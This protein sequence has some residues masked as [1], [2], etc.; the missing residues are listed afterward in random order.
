[1]FS[2]TLV[3][4]NLQQEIKLRKQGIMMVVCLVNRDELNILLTDSR[5]VIERFYN[6]V[7]VAC[8]KSIEYRIVRDYD[9]TKLYIFIPN[10]LK[11]AK[12][13]ACSIYSQV[14]LDFNREFPESY[15]KCSIQSIKFPQNIYHDVRKLLSLLNYGNFISTNKSYYFNYDD[16]PVDIETLRNKNTNLNLLRLSLFRKDAKFV[17]QP[18]VDRKTGYISYYECLLRIKDKGNK[19]VSVGPM[20]SDAE[21]KGLISIVDSTAVEMAI[22]ELN[23]DKYISLA[24]N[25]SSIGVL[26][27]KL[28]KKIEV[29]LKKYNV[30]KRLIIEITETSL[31]DDFQGTKQFIDILHKYGCRFALDDFGSGFTSFQQLLNLH[32]DIIKIDGSYIR[33]ILKNNR[34]R[35]FVKALIKLSADLGI[36]TV[37]EF[38]ENGDIAKFLIDIKI[39]GLQGNFFLPAS[40]DRIT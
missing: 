25:I 33:D 11:I 39:G 10:N 6:V 40:N 15:L 2:G 24:V 7:H 28:L 4:K 21:N 17:Y 3:I 35:L 19:W 36:E 18:I 31:N 12:K 14:Q 16:N 37:A 8:H 32:I 5:K 9:P 29:L 34:N 23:K 20:I 13:L 30:A 26:N 1:M 27:K 22:L 38:V